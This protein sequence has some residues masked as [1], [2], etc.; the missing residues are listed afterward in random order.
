[1]KRFCVLL[2]VL[3]LCGCAAPEEFET[4]SDTYTPVA[5]QPKKISLTLPEDVSKPVSVTDSA[6]VYVCDGYS[7]A[8]Q[9][10]SAGDLEATV[11]SVSGY[12]ADD[13]QMIRTQQTGYVRYDLV[14]SCAGEGGDRIARG[15]ILDD[16]AYHYT[17]TVLTEAELAARLEK[18]VAGITGSFS[19]G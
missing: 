15:V 14:W 2:L 10:L 9:T 13:L 11:R 17:L 3:A 1:M 4:L 16:G 7:I 12:A 18:T 8:L 6:G 19:L 5:V